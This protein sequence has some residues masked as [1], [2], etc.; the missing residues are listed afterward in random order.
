MPF[1]LLHA[2]VDPGLESIKD[3]GICALDLPIRA[4]VHDCCPVNPD[5]VIVVKLKEFLACKLGAII[6]DD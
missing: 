1:E 6:H 2:V 4:G 3:H 5:V